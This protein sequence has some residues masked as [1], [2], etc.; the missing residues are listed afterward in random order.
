MK[1]ESNCRAGQSV[2]KAFA[3]L[4]VKLNKNFNK[5]QGFPPNEKKINNNTY[6]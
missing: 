4:E 3:T 2:N 6:L 1:R 5:L